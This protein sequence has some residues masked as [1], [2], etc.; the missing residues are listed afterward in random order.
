[1]P[2]CRC[3]RSRRWRAASSAPA[4]SS[5][6]TNEVWSPRSGSSIVTIG[7]PAPMSVSTAGCV[8]STE[9]M[10]CP[11]AATDPTALSPTS[12]PGGTGS[13]VSPLPARALVSATPRMNSIV[14][15]SVNTKRRSSVK[16]SPI[17]R[18]RP[19]RSVRP[20]A[21]GPRYPELG[22]RLED[23]LPECRAQL[24]GP[25]VGVRH[26]GARDADGVGDRLERHTPAHGDIVPGR[27]AGRRIRLRVGRRVPRR[28]GWRPRACSCRRRA[29]TTAP[30]RAARS[31]GGRRRSSDRCR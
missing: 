21:S 29:A 23:A 15:G 14:S 24:V 8:R 4:A 26:G 3:P 13:N 27:V 9:K 11:S 25:V 22:G 31:G 30:R 2:K 17:E 20:A 7:R 6:P 1:M 28:T 10:R 5:M 19:V 12:S 18:V 16:S